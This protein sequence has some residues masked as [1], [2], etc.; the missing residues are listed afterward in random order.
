MFGG[1]T[2][3]RSSR[4]EYGVLYVYKPH[5]VYAG[6]RLDTP[7]VGIANFNSIVYL[8]NPPG[9]LIFFLHS[10]HI[11]SGRFGLPNQ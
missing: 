10:V 5:T 2:G 9:I 7:V 11:L 8:S 3:V 4:T 6:T 1:S